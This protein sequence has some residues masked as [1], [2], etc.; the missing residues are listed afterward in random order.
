[1]IRYCQYEPVLAKAGRYY[2]T[3]SLL[4]LWSDVAGTAILDRVAPARLMAFYA[5]ANIVLMLVSVF[6]GGVI[7][8]YAPHR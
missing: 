5:S 7:G 2:L 3:I 8:L 4:V 6:A 1:L